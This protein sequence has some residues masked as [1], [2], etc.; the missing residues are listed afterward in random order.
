MNISLKDIL[1]D[2]SY[3][4]GGYVL[5]DIADKAILNGDMV[6]IDMEGVSSIPTLFMNTS[7]GDLIMKYGIDKTKKIF[8]FNN[9]NR[10]QLEKIQ[11]YFNDFQNLYREKK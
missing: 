3:T 10:F 7:F 9:I 5:F 6:V 11:K 2:R 1:K 8:S 4:D